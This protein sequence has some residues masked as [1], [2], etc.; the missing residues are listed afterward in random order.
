MNKR[1]SILIPL[2]LMIFTA[3]SSTL[4]YLQELRENKSHIEQLELREIGLAISQLQNILYNR[5]TAGDEE[6]AQLSL[7]LTAMRPDVIALI[8][9]DGQ[10]KVMLSNRFAWKGGAASAHSRYS[11][12]DASLV[13]QNGVSK[14]AFNANQT[15][16]LQ[17]YYPLIVSYTRGGLEKRMGLLYVEVDISQ[18]LKE[19]S[20][21][22]LVQSLIFALIASISALLIAYVL[23]R[24]VSRRVAALSTVAGSIAAGDYSAKTNMEG[25]DELAELG[26]SFDKMAVQIGQSIELNEQAILDQKRVLYTAQEGYWKVNGEGCLKEVNDAYCKMTGYSREELLQ[27]RI[28]QLE[29]K[30]KSI[31]EVRAHMEYVRAHGTD[32]FESLHRRKDGS[33]FDV[34][35][36][37]TYW[38]DKHEFYV[39]IRD[40]TQRKHAEL[41]LQ[42]EQ[43]RLNEAQ[44]IGHFG[45]WDLNLVSGKLV[46][47][48]EIF[49]LFEIDPKKFDASYEAFL[50]VIHPDD[51]DKVNAAYSN[52]L[53]DKKSYQITHRLLMEDGRIKW[54]EERCSSSFDE[55]GKPLRSIG[56]VQDVTER[57]ELAEQARIA[58]VAFETQEAMLVTDRNN[59]IIKVNTSFTQITGYQEKDVIGKNP[60]ILS[61]GRHDSEFYRKM[62]AEIIGYGR[63]S[64]EVLDKRKDGSVYPKWLTITAV[65]FRGEV[66][67]Y[68]AV[69]VDISERKRAEEEIRNLAFYDTLTQLPN[70][71]LLL[72]RLQL[73]LG[74]S[75][76]SDH[77]CALMFLDLDHFKVLNDTRGHDYGD[78]MLREVAHRMNVCVRET[79]S[80]ARF[81]G[82]EF[83]V[84]LEGLS[85]QSEE[86]ALQ[87]GHVAEKIRDS[88]SQPYHLE[89]SVHL[90][91]PSI[92]VVL[93][94]GDDTNSEELLKQADMAMYRAK[95]G[96]RNMVRFFEPAMQAALESRTL[97]EG[98]L[99]EALDKGELK[100]NFQLQTNEAMDLLGA[101]VLLR[102]NS[103]LL[104][105]ISPA[106]FIPIA[107]QTKLILPIGHWVLESACKQLKLWENDPVLCKMHLAVNISPVQ[108]HQ[109]FFVEQVKAILQSTGADPRRLELELTENLVLED[110]D[111][112]TEKMNVLK[113]SGVRFSMD[114]FGTGYSSLQYI[115]RLPID[116]LKIDQSFVRD[117]LT[118]PGDAVMVQT[119]SDLARNFG[120]DV[121]AEG[122]ETEDQLPSLIERG[123]DM[124]QGY[125]FSRP[126]PIDD[127]EV[128]VKHWKIT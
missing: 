7:S 116:Q 40:I 125:L 123:C 80:V 27:M 18:Q 20:R 108:F 104:G 54:V 112:A 19:A 15:S 98:A 117:I 97:M 51:R 21:K 73:S 124:F 36:S 88:L 71:R 13:L 109:K 58:A 9:V 52:S 14:L 64:G 29:A 107:E 6:E 103:P 78:M 79:D 31:S 23:H 5:L 83:V 86:A 85:Q 17:G 113:Q 8:L 37:A 2:I 114:D 45:S 93:F 41:A 3:I 67:H 102:W 69:F 92:G 35:V 24:L 48:D 120:F 121:I 33:I 62:W 34:E 32:K 99:R 25:N 38:K 57:E 1:L 22:S 65:K 111:E 11:D 74:Q 63:W 75:R 12:A 105:S 106:Q 68:V 84:L 46:W 30:E 101:E 96:G 77:Y 128:L 100:L 26:R 4:I 39:F 50:N 44:K 43:D 122:V 87:A 91:T 89:H 94:K 56:T 53:E 28:P 10:G 126:I 59:R 70:R 55:S 115:K 66:T 110:I 82:D 60:S 76:R 49:H 16:V 90:S 119:I 61:S 81:G 72:D 42:L 127:F 47:S 118:D 95:D